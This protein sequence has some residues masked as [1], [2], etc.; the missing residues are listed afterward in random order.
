MKKILI[1]DDDPSILIGCSAALATIGKEIS[2]ETASD[3]EEALALVDRQDISL[4]ITDLQMPIMDGFALLA[5]LF[6]RNP[7]LPVVVMTAMDNAVG[8]LRGI[9]TNLLLQ[10]PIDFQQ[11]AQKIK[12]LLTPQANGFLEGI[13]LLGLVQLLH[14]EQKTCLLYIRSQAE[15]GSLVFSSGELSHATYGTLVGERAAEDI[16]RWQ[17]SEIAL[18]RI[19]ENYPVTIHTPLMAL[20]K[21]ASRQGGV[22]PSEQ[23]LSNETRKIDPDNDLASQDVMIGSY[24]LI[25]RLGSGG[26]G[27]VYL[28]EHIELKKRAAIKILRPELATDERN[29][30]QF[31]EEAKL[32]SKF[33]HPSIVDVY[34]GGTIPGIG[35]FITM[36]YLEGEDLHGRLQSITRLPLS[37][38]IAI[39]EQLLDALAAAHREGVLHRD[40]KP[41]N[42]FLCKTETRLQ[43]KLLDFGVAKLLDTPDGYTPPGMI[44]GTPAYMAP[45]QAAGYALDHRAD[46]YA[47]GLLLFEMLTGQRPFIADSDRDLMIMHQ[48]TPP[49]MPS[50]IVAG[51]TP[52][53]DSLVLSCLE[54]QP[55]MRPKSAARLR[56]WLLA[57]K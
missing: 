5:H 22:F 43:V 26:M 2:I 52:E 40:L 42:I 16:L 35:R 20:V 27:V 6:T 33:N 13:T 29:L 46:L 55:K 10:K 15:H 41:S 44:R 34:D 31:L 57:L 8:R 4:V 7:D 24:K 32:I 11:F 47:V 25:K 9:N 17:A 18:E 28:G 56:E 38:V 19:T 53:I 36:E 12:S 39:G 23:W 51:I 14:F 45:E 21:K 3:G 37:E 30:A 54:K 48:I 49:P 50:S 1:V